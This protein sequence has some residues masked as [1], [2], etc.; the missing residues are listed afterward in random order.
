MAGGLMLEPYQVEQIFDAFDVGW[1]P[2]PDH[3]KWWNSLPGDK[4]DVMLS[5]EAIALP[6]IATWKRPSPLWP[7]RYSPHFQHTTTGYSD[8]MVWRHCQAVAEWLG[9]GSVPEL[10]QLHRG[11]L[12]RQRIAEI[13]DFRRTRVDRWIIE[14]IR[15]A[16]S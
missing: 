1:Y 5:L 9:L 14:L 6:A 4:S 7:G 12:G 3:A 16:G 11:A 8:V 10:A 13:I 15:E 2:H